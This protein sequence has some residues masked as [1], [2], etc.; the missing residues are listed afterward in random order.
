MIDLRKDKI[1]QIDEI[2]LYKCLFVIY[3]VFLATEFSQMRS[4]TLLKSLI[5]G[6]GILIVIYE[7]YKTKGKYLVKNKLLLIFMIFNT[8]TLI[9]NDGKTGNFKFY[10]ITLIQLFIL[11]S[12]NEKK[13]LF[14]IK[15]EFR[16]LNFIFILT[17]LVFTTISV[18][19]YVFKIPVSA[20]SITDPTR[21][22]LIK[23][24]YVISTS[25]GLIC[26][27]SL[28]ATLVSLI[29]LKKD[30]RE[31]KFLTIFYFLNCFIQGYGLLLSGARGSLISFF[32]FIVVLGF[33]FI[34]NKKI[35]IGII[36][37]LVAV[38]LCFPIYKSHLSSINLF[39][40]DTEGN[41]FNGRLLLWENGYNHAFKNYKFL[42][43][44]PGNMIEVTETLADTYLPGIEGG[45][46]H[47]IY[48]DIL[49][50]NGLT[51]FLVFMTFIIY[52]SIKLYIGSF[53]NKINNENKLYIKCIA[54]FLVSILVINMV[55]SIMIYVISI[56][57]TMFWIYMGYAMKLI[58][59]SNSSLGDYK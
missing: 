1:R 36:L 6:V 40:K 9:I 35:R 27:L 7:S 12:I 4:F 13:N 25:A 47:N 56:A 42:G 38:I 2:F 55:E 58:K 46:L 24:V 45:R 37:S 50:S 10:L 11:T 34:S 19:M 17:T 57:A 29:I 49:C 28:M 5:F 22:D 43:T 30:M 44:G 52:E 48:L 15:E 18:A 23:G 32:V 16:Q 59:G 53:S 33:L 31:N 3:T 21:S 54:A 51:G 8:L 39:N 20:F 26:Y 41:F 14:S